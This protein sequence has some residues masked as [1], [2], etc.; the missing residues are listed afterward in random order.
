[1][2]VSVS[3]IQQG[4]CQNQKVWNINPQLYNFPVKYASYEEK[5]KYSSIGPA[6]L[7]QIIEEAV[8]HDLKFES[9]NIL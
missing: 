1:M 6:L 5:N 2:V 9:H 7:F 3:F 4:L 8:S